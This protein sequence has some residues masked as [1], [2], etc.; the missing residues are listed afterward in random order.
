MLKPSLFLAQLSLPLLLVSHALTTPP[1][2]LAQ[3]AT[4]P[5]DASASSQNQTLLDNLERL[6]REK[7]DHETL[8]D[9]YADVEAKKRGY[10]AQVTNIKDKTV[11]VKNID[12]AEQFLTF[13]KSTTLIRKGQET[14]ADQI[15]ISDWLNIDDW[16]VVIGVTQ[17]DQFLPRRILISSVSLAPKPKIV[18]I[19]SLTSAAAT[20]ISYLP[21]GGN[22][23]EEIK[24]DR[25]TKIQD[26]DGNPLKISQLK[27]GQEVLVT[28]VVSSNSST[29]NTI[30]VLSV[31]E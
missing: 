25:Q 14:A 15:E 28:G 19:G 12:G 5:A 29:A 27:E 20:K 11:R 10:I 21:R 2:L 22:A 18:K 9:L 7:D 23:M 6:T 1:S 3:D 24:I 13:D 26:R 16:I 17:D 8:K 4:L 30:R 31:V